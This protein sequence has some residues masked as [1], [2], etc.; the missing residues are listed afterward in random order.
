M[1]RVIRIL[2]FFFL[3]E[4]GNAYDVH[5]QKLVFLHTK[6]DFG[7]IPESGTIISHSFRFGYSGKTK[8]TAL[9]G[10]T[11]CECVSVEIFGAPF[12]DGDSGW[13]K[14]VF[15]PFSRPG[16][17]EFNIFVKA[18]NIT[19]KLEIQGWVMPKDFT[20]RE[21]YPFESGSIRWKTDHLIFG[22][23][24]EAG[25]D[26]LVTNLYNQGLKV[27][28]LDS[29]N[30]IVPRFLKVIPAS[31]IIL[32][33]TEISVTVVY[34]A[35]LRKSWGYVQDTITLITSDGAQPRKILIVSADIQQDLKNILPETKPVIV[36]AQ[37]E[38][39][40]GKISR[41]NPKDVEFFIKNSGKGNLLLRRIYSKSEFIAV[42]NYPAFISPGKEVS[43]KVRCSCGPAKGEMD[44]TLFI[45]SSDP[46]S[47]VIAVKVGWV[48]VE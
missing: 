7:E 46:E 41:S 23:M 20:Q 28:K 43:V 11:S 37:T 2:I 13:V 45:I 19:E 9:K 4:I 40:A 26:T 33:G 25:K 15:D 31:T 34:D 1:G 30:S 36:L 18:D 44:K 48:C 14:I 39:T 47:P 5:A 17:F 21:L 32:P 3:A 27:I 8:L 38:I 6:F 24:Q 22:K 35:A 29:K 10:E 12:E 42:G 16:P